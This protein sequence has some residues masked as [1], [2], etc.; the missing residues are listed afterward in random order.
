MFLTTVLQLPFLKPLYDSIILSRSTS[1]LMS[2]LH[3]SFSWENRP[4]WTWHHLPRCTW[5]TGRGKLHPGRCQGGVRWLWLVQLVYRDQGGLW[6]QVSVI[7]NGGNCTWETTVI[8]LISVSLPTTPQL[9]PVLDLVFSNMN[10]WLRFSYGKVVV[11]CAL[12]SR[13]V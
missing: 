10:P 3:S 7:T 1:L 12:F 11:V 13:W 2:V 6:S 4:V 8:K 9:N 5:Q